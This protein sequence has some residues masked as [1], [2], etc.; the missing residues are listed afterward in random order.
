MA[1]VAKEMD[2]RIPGPLL[3]GGATTRRA[4]RVKIEPNYPAHGLGAR[5]SRSVSVCTISCDA[6]SPNTAQGEEDTSA[7]RAQHKSKKGQVRIT[8]STRLAACPQDRLEP[9]LASRSGLVGVK[10]FEAYPLATSRS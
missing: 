5:A 9:L 4:H 6:Q 7:P 3:I 8:A 2:G 10:T 1:H